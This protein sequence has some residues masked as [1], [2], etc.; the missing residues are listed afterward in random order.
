VTAVGAESRTVVIRD[1]RDGE[2]T[3]RSI[4]A[5]WLRSRGLVRVRRSQA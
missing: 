1:E 4:A 3:W 5:P 2:P